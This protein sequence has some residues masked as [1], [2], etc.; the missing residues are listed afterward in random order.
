[1]MFWIWLTDPDVGFSLAGQLMVILWLL[2]LTSLWAKRLRVL[3]DGLGMFVL[4][5]V[6]GLWYLL[7]MVS[8][9]PFEQ[10]GFGSLAQVRA[11]FA[12]DELLLAG[13]LHY[14]V[15]D[16]F[17]GTWVAR[18]ARDESVWRVLLVPCLVL[19]FL[20]GPIGLLAWLLL[21]SV[22]R[23]IHRPTEAGP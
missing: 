11:L 15:F 20:A 6:I 17:V 4:P 18:Q 7:L 3:V 14:L 10:G 22:S 1:M 23:M 21:R 8:N 9:L 2:L 12:E 5:I 13:W 16:F 19:C